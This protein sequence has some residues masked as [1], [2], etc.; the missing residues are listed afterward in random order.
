AA[1]SRAN[2]GCRKTIGAPSSTRLR[3]RAGVSFW[4]TRPH[5]AVTRAPCLRCWIPFECMRPIRHLSRVFRFPWRSVGDIRRDVDDALEAW[6]KNAGSLDGV[7]GYVDSQFTWLG[8]EG[9]EQIAGGAVVGDL[10][11]LLGAAMTVGGAFTEADAVALPVVL[12]HGF[13]QQRFG[14]RRD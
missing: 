6:Q 1:L 4:R 9:P 13:W 8:P 5:G 12:S 10:F 7:A 2:G 11:P 3:V 14:G